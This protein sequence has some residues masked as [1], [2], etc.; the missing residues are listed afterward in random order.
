MQSH[1]DT[2]THYLKLSEVCHRYST[3]KSWV[4]DRIN[5]DR[6]PPPKKFG[7]MA[8]WSMGDLLQW[9]LDNGWRDQGQ[10]DEA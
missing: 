4:Y 7:C 5:E 9:E 2:N 6:F 10:E 8:R 1:I 3:G